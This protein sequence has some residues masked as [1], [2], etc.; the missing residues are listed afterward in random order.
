MP[1]K[2]LS[3]NFLWVP[4]SEASMEVPKREAIQVIE[5]GAVSVLVIY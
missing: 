1:S 2:E 5:N 3:K 4:E